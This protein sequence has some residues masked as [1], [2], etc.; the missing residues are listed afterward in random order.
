MSVKANESYMKALLAQIYTVIY[1]IPVGKVSTYGDI[2]TMAGYPGYARHVGR[3]LSNIPSESQLPWYR[4]INSRGMI[5]LK[6]T[7]FDRQLNHLIAEGIVISETGK[8]SLKQYRW[9]PTGNK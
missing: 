8:I 4:V 7:D 3:A 2:A 1:Q 5:S 6:G 9:I